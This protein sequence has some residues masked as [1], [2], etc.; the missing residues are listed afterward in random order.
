MYSNCNSV[1]EIQRSTV[2]K[3]STAQSGANDLWG[4]SASSNHRSPNNGS[5]VSSE[6][7]VKRI[8]PNGASIHENSSARTSISNNADNSPNESGLPEEKQ[9]M[10]TPDYPRRVSQDSYL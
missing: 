8:E 4:K 5:I 9:P 7:L 3:T 2:T 1:I 10:L 6:N